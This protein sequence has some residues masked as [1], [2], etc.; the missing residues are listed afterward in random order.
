MGPIHRSKVKLR[1]RGDSL[2]PDEVTARMG[3]SPTKSEKK[4]DTIIGQATGESRIARRG[5]WSLYASDCEPENIDAQ[6]TE[7]LNKLTQDLAVWQ[8]FK[9]LYKLDLFCGLFMKESNEGLE[10][11]PQ[12][13]KALGERGIVLSLDI[14]M[15]GPNK[16]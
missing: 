12:S 13:L 15:T 7:L 3:V 6:I 14:F 16:K 2:V 10:L 8:N 1:I 4:G 9:N 5:S 11:S